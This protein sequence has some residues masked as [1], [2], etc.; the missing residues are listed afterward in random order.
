MISFEE[1]CLITEAVE[2]GKT[3]VMTF[4]RCNPPTVGHKKLF[5]KVADEAKKNKAKA[6][7]FLSHTQDNKKNPLDYD[8]KL[9]VIK[10]IVP[11]GVEVVRTSSRNLTQIFAEIDKWG[12]KDV[13]FI[14]GSD[15]VNDF[16][17][18]KDG[19]RKWYSFEHFEILSA[20]ERDTDSDDF[21]STVSASMARNAVMDDDY[22]TF[23]KCCPFD[24]KK[25]Y[26]KIKKALTK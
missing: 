26:D 22:D 13:I 8:T 19:F 23:K 5:Q 2:S 11:S 17:W 21:V 20:G 16:K 4:G 10:K 18:I 25:M 14:V 1:F 15:R 6:F 9:S 7:V 3:C 12:F 24:T